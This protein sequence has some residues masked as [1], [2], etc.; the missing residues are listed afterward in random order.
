MR[1]AVL[2]KA[3][4]DLEVVEVAIDD[5]APNEVLIRT[6]ACGLCHS[7]L[8]VMDATLPVPLPSVL[9]HEAAGIVESVGSDVTGFSV[10]DHVVTCLS[11]FCGTCREC[12]AGRTYV[13]ENRRSF[14]NRLDGTP[15]LSR[16]GQHVNQLTGLGGFAEQMLVHHSSIVAV[17]EEVP[18]DRAALLGC[19][20]VTGVGSVFNAARVEPGST[21][22]V[23]GCGGIGLNIVQ[24]A[25]LAGASRVI[26]VDLHAEKLTMAT[27]FGATD[28][29]RSGDQDP[30]EAVVALTSG[31]VDHAFEAIGLP[32][33]ATQAVMMLRPGRTAYLVGV[34]PIDSSIEL[35]GAIL[36]LQGRGL[37][38]VIMGSNRFKRDIPMLADLY[39]QGR[40][41]LDELITG[42][43]PLDAVNDGFARMR[44][45]MEARSVI[46][47]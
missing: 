36:C 25:V 26:A 13:C 21:V 30:V 45:G 29:V 44:E 32:I 46:I 38:G 20:V 15:R 8:H 40:L 11:A 33:T 35:P 31:G 28:V 47:F 12:L 19:A 41:K 16:S 1:A 5:P 17:N 34:P 9:G 22:V 14:A 42:R 27:E 39:L 6:H 37:Q 4:G 3:P 2:D 24:G 7:D 10:G 23:I 18:L 43:I